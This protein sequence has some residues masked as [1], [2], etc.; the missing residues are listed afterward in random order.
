MVPETAVIQQI[1][2]SCHNKNK[3]DFNISSSNSRIT[4]HSHGI[5]TLV[6]NDQKYFVTLLLFLNLRLSQLM[7]ENLCMWGEEGEQI[8][9]KMASTYIAF[10]PLL[11]FHMDSLNS[12]ANPK[13]G[14]LAERKL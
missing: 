8:I 14:I 3:Y 7:H 13:K 6:S 4:S 2:D 12:K 10:S 9:I 5:F 11:I 1:S